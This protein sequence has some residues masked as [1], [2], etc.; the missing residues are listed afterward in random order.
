MC[1]T[2]QED[3]IEQANAI[4][5]A[6]NGHPQRKYVHFPTHTIPDG[7][8]IPTYVMGTRFNKAIQADSSMNFSPNKIIKQDS[9]LQSQIP[10]L[11][12]HRVMIFM[13]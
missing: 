1:Q 4:D 7:E 8:I 9:P 13:R 2:M 6:F 11:W 3:Y 5:G 10:M 12:G